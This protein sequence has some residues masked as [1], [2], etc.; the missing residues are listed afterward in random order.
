MSLLIQNLSCD[1]N[2][3]I[4]KKSPNSC[5]T[6]HCFIDHLHIAMY[7]T[8]GIFIYQLNIHYKHYFQQ[9]KLF[10]CNYA[11]NFLNIDLCI[12]NKNYKYIR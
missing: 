9:S 1:S 11:C 4:D 6:I 3:L 8:Q 12:K 5:N 10:S 7:I 2:P